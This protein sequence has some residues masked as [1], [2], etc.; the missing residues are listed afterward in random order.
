MTLRASR[1]SRDFSEIH[2]VKL[3]QAWS[4]TTKAMYSSLSLGKWPWTMYRIP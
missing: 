2:T 1:R 4:G 3:L